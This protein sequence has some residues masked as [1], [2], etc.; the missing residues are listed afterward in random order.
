VYA[1]NKCNAQ[2]NIVNEIIKSDKREKK[3]LKPHQIGPQKQEL[4]YAITSMI[5]I[6]LT[7]MNRIN[8]DDNRIVS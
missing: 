8:F 1:K 5:N 7:G 3:Q 6:S 4:I 2:P